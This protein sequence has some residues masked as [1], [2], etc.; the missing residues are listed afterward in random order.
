[1]PASLTTIFT[2][3]ILQGAAASLIV[4]A[5][6][7]CSTTKD[8]MTTGSVPKLTKPVEEMDATELRSA[9]DRLGQAYEKNPRD[10][11][12]GVNYAN[13]LRMNGRDTQALAVMQQVA[14]ANPGDRNVLAAYGKAQAAAGQFQQALDT[15][16]RAQTPDRPDWKLVSAQGAILDQMGRA[17]DARQRYRD[18]LDI[19]PNEPSILSNLGMSYVLTGDLRT[20]ETYLRSAAS[21]PTADSR[22]RQNLALVVGLQGRFP[23]AE[24]IARRELS[25]QQADAN[26]AYLRGMLSQQNSWQKLAAKDKTPGAADSSN[27]N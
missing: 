13:L 17:S 11:V 19:Q 18:A 23:E 12:T 5:L 14:I 3:R 9:T 20:A 25:P 24:Q 27:T 1:M 15:I 8:R 10:P 26:V 2:N 16:G 21:Q 7:G 6:A 22:V 4:L